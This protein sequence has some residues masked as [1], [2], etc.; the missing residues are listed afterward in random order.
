MV[1]KYYTDSNEELEW[2]FFTV[3]NC[4]AYFVKL[5]HV[6]L[7][8]E[9][10]KNLKYVVYIALCVMVFE[11]KWLKFNVCSTGKGSLHPYS[12]GLPDSL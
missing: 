5:S 12:T 6:H 1:S 3:V 7:T 11:I 4:S 8:G 10:G 9:D 2:K